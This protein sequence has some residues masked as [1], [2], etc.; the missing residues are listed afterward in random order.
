MAIAD[1]DGGRFRVGTVGP[2]LMHEDG[3]LRTAALHS[4]LTREDFDPPALLQDPRT[5]FSVALPDALQD[6]A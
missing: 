1:P 2:V 6:L 5:L 4:W 3:L